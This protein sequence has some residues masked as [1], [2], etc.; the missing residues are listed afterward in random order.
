MQALEAFGP[1]GALVAN[2]SYHHIGLPEWQR[3]APDAQVYAAPGAIARVSKKTGIATIRPGSEL[4]PKLP[5]DTE[6]LEVA[7]TRVFD[8]WVKR[9]RRGSSATAS[10]ACRRHRRALWRGS[11]ESLLGSRRTNGSGCYG[12]RSTGSEDSELDEPAL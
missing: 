6:I 2:N 7:A 11:R 9:A 12:A 3:A 5:S 1:V 10:S 4:A 8:V